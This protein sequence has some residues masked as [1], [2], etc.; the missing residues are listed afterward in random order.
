MRLFLYLLAIMTGFSAAQAAR[1]VV[2]VPA[3]VGAEIERVYAA[4]AVKAVQQTQ[5]HPSAEVPVSIL[6]DAARYIGTFAVGPVL[7]TP[8]LRFD[9]ILW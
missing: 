1:P 7:T 5:Y 8:V 9:V 3:S 4:V 2:A 6:P